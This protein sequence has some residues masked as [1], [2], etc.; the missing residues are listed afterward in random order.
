M[1]NKIKNIYGLGIDFGTNSVRALIL[2][3]ITGEEI[4]TSVSNFK[5]GKNGILLDDS[6]PQLARQSPGDYLESME[7]AVKAAVD[8]AISDGYDIN[9]VVGIGVDTT[10]STPLP[11]DKNMQPL[12][13]K[14]EFKNNLNAQAWLWKDH[15]SIEESIEIT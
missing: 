10:G 14:D 4:S 7:I 3:L 9:S 15:T 2:D 13:F 12:A 1:N 8:K 6:N 5:S 11:V